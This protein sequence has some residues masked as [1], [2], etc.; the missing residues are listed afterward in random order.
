[1]TYPGPL[2]DDP[3]VTW[4]D[5]RVTWD[6]ERPYAAPA[7]DIAIV[8]EDAPDSGTVEMEVVEVPE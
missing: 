4:D 7:G 1:M 8:V 5:P 6:G 2:W 3:R